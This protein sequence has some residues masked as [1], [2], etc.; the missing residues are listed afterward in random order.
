VQTK[1][2]HDLKS[3]VVQEEAVQP[4]KPQDLKRGGHEEKEP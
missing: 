1:E 2:P 3:G 4:R